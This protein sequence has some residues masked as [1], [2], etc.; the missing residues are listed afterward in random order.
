MGTRKKILRLGV[1]KKVTR[2]GGGVSSERA[3]GLESGEL[4]EKRSKGKTERAERE[5]A[6]PEG[7]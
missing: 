4:G 7:S 1:F 5:W 3:K 6:E 2:A